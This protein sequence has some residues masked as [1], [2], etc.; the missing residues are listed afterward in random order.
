M[1]CSKSDLG[2]CVLLK[3][4]LRVLQQRKKDDLDNMAYGGQMKKTRIVS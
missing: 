3:K 2:P 1:W 4:E